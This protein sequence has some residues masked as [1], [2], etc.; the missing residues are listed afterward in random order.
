MLHPETPIAGFSC[1]RD[2]GDT[3]PMRTW[4]SLAL[5]LTIAAAA[6]APATASAA[7]EHVVA[8][9]ETLSSVAAADGLSIS[10]LAAAN[11]M[12]PDSQLTLGSSLV[13]PPQDATAVSSSRLG[14]APPRPR[15]PRRWCRAPA[16]A[17]WSTWRHAERDRGAAGGQRQRAR[18]R[19][20]PEP[21]RPAIA[22]TTLHD[23]GA[24]TTGSA[25]SAAEPVCRRGLGGPA[26]RHAERDRG[27]AGRQRQRARRRQRP[28]PVRPAHRRHD[29][30]WR[31]RERARH[32][33]QQRPRW[34]RPP[35]RA[36]AAPSPPA[37]W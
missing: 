30:A 3:V 7:F 19:Q 4:K 26:W 25:A 29:A 20:R 11:A 31:R 23:G 36:T 14:R 34:C 16:G 32:R 5:T 21:V 35:P 15:P 22:G 8:K 17:L 33:R 6:W 2:T 37:R 27:A 24:A 13:I 18:R 1:L 12:S 9:G 28:E 10:Q